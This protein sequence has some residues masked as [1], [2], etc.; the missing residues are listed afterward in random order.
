MKITCIKLNQRQYEPTEK[1]IK[2]IKTYCLFAMVKASDSEYL[3]IKNKLDNWFFPMEEAFYDAFHKGTNIKRL[4]LVLAE[5]ADRINNII[6]VEVRREILD[7]LREYKY[8][9]ESDAPLGLPFYNTF[10]GMIKE[11]A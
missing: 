11:V 1:M 6:N 9:V 5:V 8:I 4:R 10:I 3:I 7:N 2:E